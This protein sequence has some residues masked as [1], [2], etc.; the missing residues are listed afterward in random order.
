[1]NLKTFDAITTPNRAKSVSPKITINTKSGLLSINK[2][3]VELLGLKEKDQVTFHQDEEE[4]TDWYIEKVKSGGFPIRKNKNATS[5]AFNNSYLAK[6]IFESVTCKEQ[7][8]SVLLAGKPTKL[9]SRTLYGLLTNS[10]IN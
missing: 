8:A 2:G 9:G 10:L 1:M 6:K 7:S 4:I 5:L 3:A